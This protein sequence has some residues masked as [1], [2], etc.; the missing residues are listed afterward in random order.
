LSFEQD[1]KN[2]TDRY[3]AVCADILQSLAA[4]D[5]AKGPDQHPFPFA[6]ARAWA[7]V[8]LAAGVEVFWR[9]YLEALCKALAISGKHKLRR[10]LRAQLVFFYD[11]LLTIGAGEALSTWKKGGDLLQSL[12]T[13]ARAPIVFRIPFDGRTVRPEHVETV[14]ELFDLP[15]PPFP[16]PIH[17]TD[18][19]TLANKRNE[20]AHGHLS[21]VTV[22]RLVTKADVLATVTR[23]SEIVDRCVLVS[24]SF[25]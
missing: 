23:V 4:E 18:L 14:W 10:H 13:D 24:G 25:K 5:A 3:A 16:S 7:L 12:V 8:W 1:I 15:T 19:D 17:R 6:Q 22:G 2:C 11:R 9:S 20:I 21:P